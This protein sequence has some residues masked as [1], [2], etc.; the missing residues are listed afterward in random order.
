[1]DRIG[2]HNDF[3]GIACIFFEFMSVKDN[4]DQDG[5]G[6]IKIDDLE[7]GISIGDCGICQDVFDCRNHITNGLNLYC[8]D[9]ENIIGFIHYKR[10]GGYKKVLVI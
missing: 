2:A 1:M 10:V 7:T 9:S 6:F 4:I 3:F 8:F 5:M